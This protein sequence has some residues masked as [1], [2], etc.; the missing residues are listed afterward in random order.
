MLYICYLYVNIICTKKTLHDITPT[1]LKNKVPKIIKIK[2]VE[3]LFN[4]TT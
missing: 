3:Q 4:L 2:I 1:D